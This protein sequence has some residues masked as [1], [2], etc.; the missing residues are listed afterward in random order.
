VRERAKVNLLRKL[1]VLFRRE[2]SVKLKIRGGI[3]FREG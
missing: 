1:T 3:N 2:V